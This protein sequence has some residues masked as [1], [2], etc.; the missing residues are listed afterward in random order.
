MKALMYLAVA[1]AATAGTIVL[2][3]H[4]HALRQVGLGMLGGFG[5]LII[6]VAV[7]ALSCAWAAGFSSVIMNVAHGQAEL[8]PGII[9]QFA[10]SLL[11][12]PAFLLGGIWILI[13][14]LSA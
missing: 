2:F 4:S 1:I 13:A 6:L 3:E 5:T 8:T 12:F 7:V 14:A 10:V 9:A 11:W